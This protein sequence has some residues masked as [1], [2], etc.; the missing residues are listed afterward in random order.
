M[1][2]QTNIEFNVSNFT[3][4][5]IP[6][7]PLRFDWSTPFPEDTNEILTIKRL[8]TR[9]PE[10]YKCGSCWAVSVVGCIN[11]TFAVCGLTDRHLNLSTTYALVKYP[12][13]RCNGGDPLRLLKDIQQNGISTK[14]CI[15]YDWCSKNKK[16][17]GS[18]MD[19][20]DEDNL[21]YLVPKHLPDDIDCFEQYFVD[22]I[23][24]IVDT[25]F[26]E[27]K[28]TILTIQDSI[29][30]HILNYGPVVAGFFVFKNFID[31]S[32]SKDTRTK[33]IY[34]EK[35]YKGSFNS[36]HIIQENL[37]GGHAIGVVGWGYEDGVLVDKDRV[38][39][40]VPY[41]VCRNSWGTRW[42]DKGYFKIAMYPYNRKVQFIKQVYIG[43]QKLGG[44]LIF[45][46]KQAHLTLSSYQPRSDFHCTLFITIITILCFLFYL[47]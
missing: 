23:K 1:F 13:G 32:F 10:Q 37:L 14:R 33:G 22:D 45:K 43:Y 36:S 46:P 40:N 20:W 27:D 44:V 9:P 38:Q 11:D 7:L 18:S 12:Q 39:D 6:P 35:H 2:K 21:N 31:G 17:N 16:C 5:H 29:K 4:D 30:Y 8:I 41:W 3:Y 15:N 47:F 24:C 42:G 26:N 19:H 28:Q 25:T 34:F